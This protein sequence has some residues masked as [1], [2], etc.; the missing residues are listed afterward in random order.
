MD[1]SKDHRTANYWH[2][3]PEINKTECELCPRH[4]NLKDGQ[5]GF[6]Q[7]RG[8]VG[9]EMHTYNYGRS[10]QATE[11]CIETEAI[12]HFMPGAKILSMGN[13]GCM[14]SCSYC[15]NWQT[16]QIKHL[17]NDNVKI[18]TPEQV[19]NMALAN[20]IKVISWTYNDPV[21]WQEFVVDTSRLAKK[22]GITTLYK[23][24][25]YIEA[26]P[27]KELIE[28]IDIFSI[29]LKSMNPEVYRKVT[30]GELEP[31]LRGIKQI[32]ASGRHL[33]ISQLVV[34]ELN[35]DGVDARKTAIWMRE[36]LGTHVP[37]HLVAYHPAFRYDK[38]R[39]TVETL[40]RLRE[41]VMEEGISYC[42]LGNVYA[43]NVSNTFCKKCNQKLVERFG[44]TV[45]V[46]GLDN[47][48]NCIS[49]GKHSPIIRAHEGIN[50]VK[51][52]YSTFVNRQD[53]EFTWNREGNSLHVVM[54]DQG[55]ENDVLLQVQ[56]F[57]GNK[58]EYIE[59]NRGLERVILSRSGNEDERIRI[60]A[61]TNNK[62][63][64]L[65]VLDRA[66]FPVVEDTT[67]E[68][69]FLN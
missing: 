59:M 16:S 25:L 52:D 13:V 64:Y 32:A 55:G 6:C 18:Y 34:T 40:L 63:H 7:V 57:P 44:L 65:P 42:Y 66:H 22:N 21:V 12:N 53:Y 15:Q 30:K 26:E 17:N 56:R 3:M 19:I 39:T 8:N 29:S 24:A 60:S 37:L 48:G 1:W 61:D 67:K 4:C 27:L 10:V 20:K 45:T 14:M 68:K 35:D 47:Q 23:S 49:C 11:E 54:D 31:V 33:E 50:T 9:N 43:E 41:I 69:K 2:Y 62:I 28:V 36:N 5:M 58:L 38:P 46:V 51:K